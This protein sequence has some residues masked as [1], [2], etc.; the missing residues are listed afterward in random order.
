MAWN[1]TF[2][3]TTDWSAVSFVEMF[4]AAYNERLQATGRSTVSLPVAGNDVQ[5]AGFWNTLQNW[6][7][8]NAT[9]FLDPSATYEGL[10]GTV[11]TKQ[12]TFA[13][14]L[15]LIGTST[16]WR[17]KR[18]REISS[19]VA[20]TDT[21]GNA[22]ANGMRA[23]YT[24]DGL[25]YLRAGGAWAV[26]LTGPPD[27]LDS[28]SAA[29][30]TVSKGAMSAGDYI[31]PWVFN[32]IRDA[33][34]QLIYTYALSDAA[35]V[36]RP[37]KMD[38]QNGEENTGA[39]SSA[40]SE[41]AS[42]T[43]AEGDYA[44]LTNVVNLGTAVAYPH[45]A[46]SVRLTGGSYLTSLKRI[47]TEVRISGIPTFVSCD[48]ELYYQAEAGTADAAVTPETF[49]ANGDDV[50]SNQYH[51]IADFG[52]GS[53]STTSYQLIGKTGAA[54]L[55]T[56]PGALGGGDT[57]SANGHQAPFSDRPFFGLLKWNVAGGFTYAP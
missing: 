20:A 40:V 35:A 32:Q 30:D 25:I 50:L 10:T 8:T 41:A 56:W 47:K 44:G 14:V 48:R 55:P 51:K 53:G 28:N 19:T 38:W 11:D 22:V 16:N 24:G 31:G 15:A 34:N 18:P 43:A 36:G 17:R 39:G 52:I 45:A 23:I 27:T 37:A 33:F 29:P 9:D 21:Q 5:S 12:L 2:D 49:D 54:D 6:I 46:A 3:Q 26:D 7:S 1:D 4:Y 57:Q 13:A 42:R